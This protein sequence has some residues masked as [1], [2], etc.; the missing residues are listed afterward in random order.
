[1]MQS[2]N[3]TSTLDPVSLLCN[4]AQQRGL[5]T[6]VFSL[7][8][9]NNNVKPSVYTWSC[10]WMGHTVIE[11]ASSRREARARAAMALMAIFPYESLPSRS[12]R[13]S[14]CIAAL[15][16]R[17]YIIVF[18][19]LLHVS[20]FHMNLILYCTVYNLI[21]LPLFISQWRYHPAGRDHSPLLRLQRFGS[22]RSRR[23]KALS[24]CSSSLCQVTLTAIYFKTL[25]TYILSS[26]VSCELSSNYW[27]YFTVFLNIYPDR[28]PRWLP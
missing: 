24:G 4:E 17:F 16:K 6:P 19:N 5:A 2:P 14:H 3:S 21:A 28:R 15:N 13:A 12:C 7:V 26:L 25:Y 9:I 11:S 1:M 22:H 10:H 23:R 8:S 20:G 18:R 27:I